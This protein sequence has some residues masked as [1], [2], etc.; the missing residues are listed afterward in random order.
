MLVV[1]TSAP[2]GSLTISLSRKQTHLALVVIP[3]L[4]VP[5]P[6]ATEVQLSVGE[7]TPHL[8]FLFTKHQR[9]KIQAKFRY[10]PNLKLIPISHC[11]PT[12]RNASSLASVSSKADQKLYIL[13]KPWVALPIPPGLTNFD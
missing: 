2:A 7:R 1:R 4:N 3:L 9:D 11:Y 13:L 12:Y 5:L 8:I 10:S 6:A